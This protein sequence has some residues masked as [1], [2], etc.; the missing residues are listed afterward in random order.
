[1]YRICIRRLISNGPSLDI[2]GLKSERRDQLPIALA[3]LFFDNEYMFWYYLNDV[4]IEDVITESD[5]SYIFI[6]PL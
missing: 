5:K 3:Q 4:I 2:F 6:K 1:M